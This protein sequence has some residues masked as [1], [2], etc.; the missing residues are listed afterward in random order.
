MLLLS[1]LFS[2]AGWAQEITVS[3]SVDKNTVPLNN[4][5]TLQIAVA[6]NISDVSEPQL[7][8][9]PNFTVYSSGRSQNISIINGQVSSSVL[10]TYALVPRFVG[11][12]TIG[13][14][15]IRQA[16]KSYKTAPIEIQ[17]VRPM[18]PSGAGGLSRSFDQNFP[19]RPAPASS[20]A[21]TQANPPERKRSL[22][23]QPVFATAQTDKKTVYVNEP[24]LL[25]IR[26]YTSLNLMGNPEYIPP[27]LTGFFHEDLPPGPSR[28]IVYQ[29]RPYSVTEIK[30]ALFPVT[31]GMQTVGPAVIRCQIREDS[32]VD[33]FSP[34]FFQKFFSQGL[35]STQT[36]ELQTNPIVLQVLE[37]PKQGK[38]ARFSGAVGKFSFQTSIDKPAIQA[39]QPVTLTAKI[40]GEGNLKTIGEP[41]WPDFSGLRRYETASSLNL[42]KTSDHVTGT[43][44]FKTILI[45]QNPGKLRLAGS[46][47]NYFDPGIKT[48]KTLSAPPL[49]IQVLPGLTAAGGRTGASS[50][51]Q[52][53]TKDIRYIRSDPLPL[54]P[55]RN[56][57][58]PPP[59]LHVFPLILF[60]GVAAFKTYQDRL[61]RNP[62]VARYRK[63][64]SRSESLIAEAEKTFL[65][66]KAEQGVALL[67]QSLNEYLAS[68]LRR[69]AATMTLK[70]TLQHLETQPIKK[71]T[72]TM[73]NLQSIWKEL[74]LLRFAPGQWQSHQQGETEIPLSQRLAGLLKELEKS[75]P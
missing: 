39:G 19:R 24:V 11:K 67:S 9:M 71:R 15:E 28:Q 44:T 13:P 48:Y 36:K 14:V 29:G 52:V 61:N 31:A 47:F 17:V 33:P 49:D 73:E 8:S 72:E 30:S 10:F 53:Y 55:K 12:S 38:P 69:P 74:E 42:A 5:V 32:E 46:T 6:G 1:L 59:W 25:T 43:K 45:P 75:F 57:F 22:P 70:Q 7:P 66:G 26:F 4:Q 34:D 21:Q 54:R 3:A 64:L 41:F 50:N 63:A 62:M 37:L 40:S 51:A 35:L 56:I 18:Q 60:L 65:H 27:K 20:P 58:S 23:G 68:K 2:C 16:G